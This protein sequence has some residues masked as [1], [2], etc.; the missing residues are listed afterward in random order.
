MY[1]PAVAGYIA[2]WLQPLVIIVIASTSVRRIRRRSTV[3]RS[4]K[5]QGARLLHGRI[6]HN[7]LKPRHKNGSGFHS[8][9]SNTNWM[10]RTGKYRWMFGCLGC[11]NKTRNSDRNGSRT[12]EQRPA[13]SNAGR[14][15]TRNRTSQ[16]RGSGL[17]R[18]KSLGRRGKRNDLGEEPRIAS[19]FA[20]ALATSRRG[21]ARESVI[22]VM[23]HNQPR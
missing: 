18:S 16:V 17:C 13:N 11:S 19:R 23:R 20:I 4:W 14:N 6:L 21:R 1:P 9:R 15:W 12:D 5:D 8:S 3:V 2:L 10:R 22:A 7:F